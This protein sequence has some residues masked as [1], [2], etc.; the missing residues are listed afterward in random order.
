MDS[1]DQTENLRVVD[2]IFQDLVGELKQYP[3]EYVDI[4]PIL[5]KAT[6]KAVMSIFFGQQLDEQSI[7][8]LDK[9]IEAISKLAEDTIVYSEGTESLLPI[10]LSLTNRKLRGRAGEIQHD[11]K[12]FIMEWIEN[13]KHRSGDDCACI[14]LLTT[15][16]SKD[17]QSI[18]ADGLS[19]ENFQQVAIL[20]QSL[21][22]A[23]ED[24]TSTALTFALYCL[25]EDADQDQLY[26]QIKALPHLQNNTEGFQSVGNYRALMENE[27]LSKHITETLRLYPTAMSVPRK[28]AKACSFKHEL[29]GQPVEIQLDK[30]DRVIV[31]AIAMH[32]DPA[33]F[34]NPEK[35]DPD[36]ADRV[37]DYLAY[38]P[39]RQMNFATGNHSCV[40]R[41][42][43]AFEMSTCLSRLNQAFTLELSP[44]SKPLELTSGPTLSPRKPIRIKFTPR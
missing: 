20:L 2:K 40:G 4:K 33:S 26:R 8:F 30:G 18:C 1:T 37:P 41:H 16:C 6:G 19:D 14:Q 25:A 13:N 44:E 22:F 9:S 28:V 34:A 15:I 10:A 36:R 31:N 42:L 11:I 32:R 3:D 17:W 7:S 39:E 38:N 29:G 21:I 27:E 43:A 24:T 5:A 35:F 12:T 23:A